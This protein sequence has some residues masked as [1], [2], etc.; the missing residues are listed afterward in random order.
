V[1]SSGSD[2]TG[3]DSHFNNIVNGLW[4]A[5]PSFCAEPS[6]SLIRAQK[7][8]VDVRLSLLVK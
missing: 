7:K 2:E 6:C 1:K 8:V 3:L 5:I 4:H